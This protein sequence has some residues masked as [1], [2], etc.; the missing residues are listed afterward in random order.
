MPG[1]SA[2]EI[3][4]AQ[5]PKTSY[6]ETLKLAA[7]NAKARRK[8]EWA[9]AAAAAEA[10]E[11]EEDEEEPAPKRARPDQSWSQ[12]QLPAIKASLDALERHVEDARLEVAENKVK[13][14]R[15]EKR[16]TVIVSA[17]NEVKI[18]VHQ[19]AAELDARRNARIDA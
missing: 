16:L 10:E 17:L 13:L 2:A 7:T 18:S 1:R 6:R 8:T 15:S 14:D 5:Y 9:Q 11:D 19:T 12:G 4:E 3:F